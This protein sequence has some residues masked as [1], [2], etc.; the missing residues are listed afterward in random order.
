MDS[1]VVLRLDPECEKYAYLTN[2]V[3]RKSHVCSVSHL[4]YGVGRE[5][6]EYCTEE[7]PLGPKKSSHCYN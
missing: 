3:N 7:V 4:P 5:K 1:T 2:Q 6:T